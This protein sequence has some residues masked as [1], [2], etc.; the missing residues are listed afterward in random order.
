MYGCSGLRASKA[1][2]SASSKEEPPGLASTWGPRK[3][4]HF[5]RRMVSVMKFQS[6]SKAADCLLGKKGKGEITRQIHSP[7]PEKQKFNVDTSTLLK[8]ND[9]SCATIPPNRRTSG[10]VYLCPQAIGWAGGFGAEKMMVWGR[11][12]LF[13]ELYAPD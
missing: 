5:L 12:T 3:S 8:I 6:V 13:F 1:W 7:R 4:T 10:R 11:K 9:G 2:H